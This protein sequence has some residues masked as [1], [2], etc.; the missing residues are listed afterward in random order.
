MYLHM[1]YTFLRVYFSNKIVYKGSRG[2]YLSKHHIFIINENPFCICFFVLDR[3]ACIV[4]AD[5]KLTSCLSLLNTEISG[6]YHHI[7]L[8]HLTFLLSLLG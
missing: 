3:S 5:L 4:Q 8:S 7:L 6:V 2:K 1:F